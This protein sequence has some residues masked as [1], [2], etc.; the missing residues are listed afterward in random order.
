MAFDPDVLKTLSPDEAKQ[1]IEENYK[2]YAPTYDPGSG[3]GEGATGSRYDMDPRWQGGQYSAASVDPETG[4]KTPQRVFLPSNDSDRN[5]IVDIGDDG[6]PS[7]VGRQ[8]DSG[9]YGKEVAGIPIGM[10]LPIAG[11]AAGAALAGAGIGS[12][13][14]GAGAGGIS[15]G[16]MAGLEAGLAGGAGGAGAGGISAG[17]MAGLEAGLPALIEGGVG[18][19]AYNAA[20]AAGM[21]A[22]QATMAAQVAA[23]LEGSG[24]ATSAIVSSGLEAAGAAGATGAVG[25]GG[26]IVGG[27][28]ALTVG[29]TGATGTSAAGLG[30]LLDKLGIKNVK[31]ALQ[32]GLLGAGALDL[33]GGNKGSGGTGGGVTNLITPYTLNREVNPQAQPLTSKDAYAYLQGK[34][35]PTTGKAVSTGQ[36][37]WFNDKFTQ[38]NTYNPATGEQFVQDPVSGQMI[39]LKNIQDAQAQVDA[40]KTDTATGADGGIVMLAQGGYAGLLDGSTLG[41][42]SD[43]G[44]LLR[45]PGD[46]VSD[47][48]PATIGGKQPARLADGE[49]VVPARI[50]SELGNGSTEAGARKLYKMMDRIQSNRRKTVGKNAVAK[51]SKADKHLPA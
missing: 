26:S 17:T 21:T 42:Y 15:A 33:L 36:Q 49:F 35:S 5:Y 32:L 16:T 48:I 24:M 43:G 22:E 44:R 7:Y 39:P 8:L 14:A 29:L 40:N 10:F 38:Q 23:G 34:A 3:F 18:S 46:G 37:N 1:Y 12:G 50:V 13:A 25:A 4:E 31:D 51:D 19:Q 30:G 11:A 20:I 27:G 28:G 41:G 45:G 2:F 47:S 6:K 9:W